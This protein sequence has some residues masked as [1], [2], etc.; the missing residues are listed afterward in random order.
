M[1]NIVAVCKKRG[2][3]PQAAKSKA[4]ELAIR[5]WQNPADG[6]LEIRRF[7]TYEMSGSQYALHEAAKKGDLAKA[8]EILDAEPDLVF[9]EDDHGMTPLHNAVFARQ[10]EMV[11]FLLSRK[12]DVNAKTKENVGMLMYAL[13]GTTRMVDLL[14][15]HGADVNHKPLGG[16]LTITQFATVF[17]REDIAELLR[18]HGAR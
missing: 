16:L 18:Q 15:T 1:S 13:M 3:T 11:A 5:W 17:G 6:D 2:L 7:W 8:Q 9:S 10:E 12:A 4:R 14:L